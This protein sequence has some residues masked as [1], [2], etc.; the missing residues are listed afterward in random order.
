VR[1]GDADSLWGDSRRPLL[2]SEHRRPSVRPL[3]VSVSDDYPPFGDGPYPAALELQRPDG[4]RDRVSVAFRI[5]LIIPHLL[6][7]W[8][9]SI[10]WAIT[11]VVA[12][13]AILLTGRYPEE[14]YHFGVGVLRWG[15]RVEAY[16]LLLHDEYPP[17]S[18]A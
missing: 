9:L 13:I 18:L 2:R 17:F 12:W 14:L 10:G 7:V 3:S 11:T 8:A 4:P 1:R 15:T 6:A 16:V 5:I